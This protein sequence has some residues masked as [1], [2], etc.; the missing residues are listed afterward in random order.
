MKYE[1]RVNGEQYWPLFGPQLRYAGPAQRER[2]GRP[3]HA[4]GTMWVQSL[5]WGLRQGDPLSPLLF[6]ITMEALNAKFQLADA[7]SMF[8]SLQSHSI[9]HR[10]SL[11]TNDMAV[12]LVPVERDITL[13]RTI[14]DIFM[15]SL[16]LRIDVS[17]CQYTPIQCIEEQVA[18]VQ[19]L[20]PCQLIHLPCQ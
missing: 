20:F 6:V 7:R 9:Q 10:V 5:C 15:G 2:V 16:G 12:F 8:T 4:S 14:P 3:A 17:K 11:Y 1:N 18:L 19:Q 13:T